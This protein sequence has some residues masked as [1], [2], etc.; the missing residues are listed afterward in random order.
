MNRKSQGHSIDTLFTFLLLLSFLLF[1]LLVA[2]TGSMVYQN[3]TNSLNENYTSRTAL[4]YLTEKLRQHDHTDSVSIK[5]LDGIPALA[6]YEEQNGTRYCTYLYFYDGA[7][8]ELFTQA[9]NPPS[10]DM[11]TAIAELSDFTFS[12]ESDADGSEPVLLLTVTD[13]DGK[14]ST[15]RIHLSAAACSKSWSMFEK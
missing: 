11:G 9:S 5:K 15:A 3:G 6:L 13:P 14:V 10:A 2:G 1:S 7:L 4:S 8:R 12:T